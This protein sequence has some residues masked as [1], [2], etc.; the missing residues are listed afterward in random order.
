MLK[1]A[2][3]YTSSEY[4]ALL[5]LNSPLSVI[6]QHDAGGG[7]RAARQCVD[8]HAQVGVAVIASN[9]LLTAC[10]LRTCTSRHDALIDEMVELG[11]LHVQPNTLCVA[12]QQPIFFRFKLDS[13]VLQVSEPDKCCI[14]TC[15]VKHTE[16]HGSPAHW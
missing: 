8:V 5:L 6:F 12:A 10:L 16:E 2:R 7:R 4:S 13:H 9:L 15:S 3:L 11:D 1:M 14:T